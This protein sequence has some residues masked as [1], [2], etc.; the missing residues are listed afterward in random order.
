LKG[1]MV[2][3]SS[4]LL[5][6]HHSQQMAGND[7]LGGGTVMQRSRGKNGVHNLTMAFMFS[8]ATGKRRKTEKKVLGLS[9]S[10]SE[11]VDER[12]DDEAELDRP[13][14]KSPHGAAVW[15]PI[16]HR[17]MSVEEYQEWEDKGVF[18]V[19]SSLYQ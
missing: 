2:S 13:V 19:F 11:K 16:R 6:Y 3:L 8:T 14:K 12:G 9:G 15:L 4:I 1:K 17:K 10:V 5:H 18:V 7:S